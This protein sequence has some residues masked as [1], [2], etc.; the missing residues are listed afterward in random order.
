MLRDNAIGDQSEITI[1]VLV[2]TT[3]TNGENDLTHKSLLDAQSY[4]HMHL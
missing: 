4:T 1:S 3:K 2:I